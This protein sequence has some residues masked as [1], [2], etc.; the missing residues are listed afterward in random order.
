MQDEYEYVQ[1]ESG[2]KFEAEEYSFV[3]PDITDTYSKD[4]ERE[5]TQK[6]LETNTPIDIQNENAS[7][8]VDDD[9]ES[10][11]DITA[12]PICEFVS[13]ISILWI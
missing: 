11:D 6:P 3:K 7:A 4:E 12:D 8:A 10:S 9:V 13:I 5:E 1:N 2:N